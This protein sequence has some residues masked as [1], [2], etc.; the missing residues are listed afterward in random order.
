MEWA[1]MI[2]HPS[3]F[4]PFSVQDHILL[5]RKWAR[6]DASV[7]ANIENSMSHEFYNV[8]AYACVLWDTFS[9]QMDMNSIN[10][11]A[12][13]QIKQSIIW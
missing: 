6:E 2:M 4:E 13:Y 11:W 1:N 12:H 5:E 8:T 10:L 7:G 9:L 3:I